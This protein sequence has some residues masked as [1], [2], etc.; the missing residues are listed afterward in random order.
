MSRSLL[1]GLLFAILAEGVLIWNTGSVLQEKGELL[2][3]Q[4]PRRFWEDLSLAIGYYQTGESPVAF[5]AVQRWTD[6]K[7][8]TYYK[9]RGGV[10]TN[11]AAKAR[12]SPWHFWRGVPPR[13]LDRLTIDLFPRFDDVGRSLL[14]G[15]SFRLLGGVAPYLLFWLGALI[16]FPLLLWLAIEVDLSGRPLAA[17]LGTLGLGASAFVADALA[18]AYSSAGFYVLGV[19]LLAPFAAA[20][21]LRSPSRSGLLWKSL[22]AGTLLA[23]LIAC[24]SGT[25][26]LLPGF[27]L[28]ALAGARRARRWRRW[29]VWALACALLSLPTLGVGKAVDRLTQSTFARRAQGAAPPQHHAIWFGLWTGLGDFDREKGHL[30]NDA[31]ASAFMVQ[32]GGSPLGPASYNP[33][34]EEILRDAIIADVLGDP[35]WY[36]GILAR[37]LGAT[38]TQWNILPWTPLSGKASRF[39]GDPRNYVASYYTLTAHID[40]VRFYPLE[41]EVPFWTLILGTLGLPLIACWRE[42]RF[43]A[44]LGVGGLV[45]PLAITTAGAIEPMSFGL[46]YILGT[47]LAVEAFLH[48]GRRPSSGPCRS[49]GE[50]MKRT[51]EA[52]EP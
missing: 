29:P 50:R 17:F 51:P 36:L 4:Q 23:I 28:A 14:L 44:A 48:P 38:L 37:R 18:L 30:W 47:A 5:N 49:V 40:V 2:L 11:A 24:R 33:R 52:H 35:G 12:L 7:G 1:R 9:E 13:A 42:A 34:N 27:G 39:T 3:V 46:T 19:L 41:I 10:I 26:F 21:V 20:T 31:A 6:E 15:H 25:L 8:D 45:L 22:L 16:A 32:R 43:V